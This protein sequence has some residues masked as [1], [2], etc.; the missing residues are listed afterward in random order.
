MSVTFRANIAGPLDNSPLLEKWVF[1]SGD[2]ARLISASL[3]DMEGVY[4]HDN[5][6]FYLPYVSSVPA[7]AALSRLEADGVTLSDEARAMFTA[8][9]KARAR[10]TLTEVYNQTHKMGLCVNNDWD[11]SEEVNMTSS[12]AHYVFDAI[13]LPLECPNG[14]TCGDINVAKLRS[15]VISTKAQTAI[16]EAFLNGQE[17]GCYLLSRITSL[18]KL[19]E[20]AIK[21]GAEDICFG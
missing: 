3:K 14:D 20:Y 11:E 2:D 7:T 13:G 5:D 8:A 1:M 6:E 18:T 17:N 21:Q 15:A 12:N 16:A 10:I 9:A 4:H 19:A